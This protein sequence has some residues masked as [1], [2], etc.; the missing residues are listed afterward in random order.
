M[1]VRMVAMEEVMGM[2]EMGTT[3]REGTKMTRR[4]ALGM[5]MPEMGTT[6]KSRVNQE[7]V[8]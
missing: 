2:P 4:M 6:P 3:Q 7:P 8:E 1:T 5:G